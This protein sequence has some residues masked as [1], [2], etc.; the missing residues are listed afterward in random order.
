M[1]VTMVKMTMH[2]QQPRRV[3][4]SA[5]KKGVS[6]Y[7]SRQEK[8]GGVGRTPRGGDLAGWAASLGGRAEAP[9]GHAQPHTSLAWQNPSPHNIEHYYFFN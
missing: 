2:H 6:F 5:H 9:F 3:D 4:V 8:K 7:L 1:V